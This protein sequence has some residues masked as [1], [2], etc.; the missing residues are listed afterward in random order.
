MVGIAFLGAGIF[1]KEAHLPAI[2]E[3][4][5]N[6]L[7]VYSRSTRSAESLKSAADDLSIPTSQVDVYSDEQEPLGRGLSQLLDRSDIA[8]VIVVLP[9]LVQPDVVRRCLAAGKHV[10]CEKPIAK[11]VA[12]ASQLIVE[13]EK[14]FL[15]KSLVFSIAEQFRYDR[16]FTHVRDLIADGK[17]GSLNH[18]HARVWGNI[19]PGSNKW[20]ET[21]WRKNPEY[22]GGFVLDGGVH[23]VALIRYISGQEVVNTT[24]LVSQTYKHLPPLDT[25][26][27]ALRFENGTLG[28]L[29]I[30]FASAKK[31][32]EFIFVGDDKVVTVSGADG[33]SRIKLED[34][35]GK[36][37]SAEVIDGQGVSEEIKAFLQ[38][39]AIGKA[40]SR[41]GPREALADLA[42][43][44]S[45]C[46][47]GGDVAVSL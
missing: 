25:V 6:L 8:A 21:E 14:E 31:I 33:G 30:S 2:A 35:D 37:L 28:S 19:E 36:V 3:H 47:G 41:A 20:Y 13:Y 24:S 11:D 16:A 27:A 26:N 5:A 1:A 22:Q 12:A 9:I 44:E 40:D 46:S 4:K 10:L 18:V 23:F 34:G 32:F 29:S 17:I 45:I 42:V 43:I 7:A 15:P 38:A 39:A